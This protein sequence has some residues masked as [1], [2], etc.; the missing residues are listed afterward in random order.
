MSLPP[1]VD[2]SHVVSNGK[3]PL[4]IDELA[5]MQPGMDRLMAEVGPRVSTTWHAAQAG[6]WPM[7]AYYWKS[8][9]KQLRLCVESRPKYDPEMTQYVEVECAAVTAALK[10]QDAEGFA[11]AYDAMV[12]RAN[13]LHAHF[14]KPFLVWRTDPEPPRDLDLQAGL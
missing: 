1:A 13:A 8:A 2:H 10:A 14:G 12:E 5:R 7:A 3:R 6:N 11:R 9:V 4:S